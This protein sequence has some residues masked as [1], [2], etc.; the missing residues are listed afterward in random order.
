MPN[1]LIYAAVVMTLIV[2]QAPS[3]RAADL[4]R[5]GPRVGSRV[6]DFSLPDQNGRRQSLQ[7]I[8]GPN[9]GVLVFFRSAD[10]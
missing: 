8:L 6:P 4:S 7:S 1:L 9:G 10:W 3:P 5:V 2:G